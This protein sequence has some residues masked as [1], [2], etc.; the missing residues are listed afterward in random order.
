MEPERKAGVGVV[1]R[2]SSYTD[3]IANEICE[4][5]ANGESLIGICR[6]AHMPSEALVRRWNVMDH[7]GFAAK[8][9]HAREA[10]M[11]AFSDQITEIVENTNRDDVQV[12]RLQVD[13]RKWLM[14]KLAPK[15]YGD[16]LDVKTD[17]QLVV[18]VLSFADSNNPE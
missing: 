1:S 4:R 8:Y 16:K 10:Q 18:R 5:L 11:E 17:G 12:A 14:S 2:P 7:N 6:D 13:A 9:A 3:E 15:K